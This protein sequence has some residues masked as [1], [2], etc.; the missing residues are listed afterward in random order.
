MTYT[1][2]Q[3]GAANDP[4]AHASTTAPEAQRGVDQVGEEYGAAPARSGLFSAFSTRLRARPQD[5][6]RP[7][8]ALGDTQT[9]RAGEHM[10]RGKP[11]PRRQDKELN[12]HVSGESSRLAPAV[13]DYV[14]TRRDV[15][16]TPETP[17]ERPRQGWT[18][19]DN[20]RAARFQIAHVLRAFDK[21]IADHPEDVI[22]AEFS[23]PRAATP[24]NRAALS[25]SFPSPM[26]SASTATAGVG[27]QRN[28]F[29][30]LPRPWDA[31]AVN[32]GG[33]AA[34]GTNDPS[35]DA[36]ARPARRGFRL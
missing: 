14:N 6:P 28:T 16:I 24:P 3:V 1:P 29:R 30:L 15:D 12:G 2:G 25:D 32:T 4:D 8:I 33:P 9:S 34:T 31:T 18:G 7:A 10:H 19:A 21:N 27:V 13:V 11:D 35:T 5:S 22:K 23:S 26:G 17:P 20:T 36:A